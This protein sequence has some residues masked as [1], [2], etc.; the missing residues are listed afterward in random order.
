MMPRDACLKIL[1]RHRTDELVV[2]VYRAAFEW[3]AIAPSPLNYVAVGAMGQAS[4]HGLGLAIGRP[5][6]RVWVLD[7]D[8]SLLMNL[9]T[10]VT[11]AAQAPR[12]LVHFV[13]ENGVYEVNGNHPIPGH[14]RMDLAAMARAA[15]YR[16]SFTFDQIATF[17]AGIGEIL[18]LEG[19]VFVCLRIVPGAE[20]PMDWP[21]VHGPEQRD[22]FRAALR[23]QPPISA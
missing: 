15:G 6:R 18:T 10:L 8:G 19:P 14:G 13:G 9:G 22:A 5:D 1:A 23:A 4:S 11:I 20:Y 16:H 2:S 17:A 3:K 21:Y 12:N 7:G